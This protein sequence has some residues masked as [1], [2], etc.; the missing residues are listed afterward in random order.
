LPEETL[1]DIHRFDAPGESY[2]RF[3]KYYPHPQEE[4]IQSG[5]VWLKGHTDMGTLTLLYSQPVAALQILSTEPDGS[6]KWRWIK[7]I[8]NSLVVNAGDVLDFLSGGKY[9]AT[10]H[11]VVQP[12]QDQQQCT[13]L[14]MFYFAMT[15]DDVIL[16]PLPGLPVNESDPAITKEPLTMEAWRK[17]RTS[18]Y[19][20][21]ELKKSEEAGV[22][23]QVVRGVVVKHYN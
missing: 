8:E 19:G 12:P 10:V 4:E 20:T 6:R 2:V 17:E 7:H 1:V 14:G 5:G 9:K 3:M 16:R 11:R 22:E 13:R 18:A 21:I 15:D 23:E